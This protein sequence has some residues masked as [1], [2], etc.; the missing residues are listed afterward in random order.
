MALASCRP[1]PPWWWDWSSL[2]QWTSTP[3]V[4]LLFLFF[5][6]WPFTSLFSHIVKIWSCNSQTTQSLKANSN[7]NCQQRSQLHEDIDVEVLETSLVQFS[8]WHLR[9]HGKR[10]GCALS[11]TSFASSSCCC[12][13]P[14]LTTSPHLLLGKHKYYIQRT[15]RSMLW[16]VPLPVSFLLLP[17]V[18]P[19]WHNSC[20]TRVFLRQNLLN[21]TILWINHYYE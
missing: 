16:G 6:R 10:I 20:K 5:W 3:I 18:I 17:S 14:M 12:Y 8:A 4:G 9:I 21:K 19:R 2:P 1:L 13:C 7:H 15:W 11:M